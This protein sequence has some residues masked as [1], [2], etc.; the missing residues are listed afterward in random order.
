MITIP[1]DGDAAGDHVF[2]PSP[3]GVSLEDKSPLTGVSSLVVLLSFTAIGK[4]FT[5][6]SRLLTNEVVVLI[7][8]LVNGVVFVQ[9]EAEITAAGTVEPTVPALDVNTNDMLFVFEGTPVN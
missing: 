2:P 7:P 1:L 3:L 8:V 6:K 4:D 9:L 5:P